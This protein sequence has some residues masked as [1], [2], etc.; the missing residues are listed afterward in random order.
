[1]LKYFL[2]YV[3]TGIAFCA[4]D[5]AWL[6]L[7]APKFY[8]AQIGQ[9]LL[10]KPNFLPALVFYVLYTGGLVVF[11]V[12]PAINADEWTHALVMGALFGLVAYAT[13]DLSNLATLKGWSTSL[14]LVDIAWGASASSA[15][16]IFGYFGTLFA[17]RFTS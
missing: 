12:S 3:A 11:C 7:V 4:L 1:M 9:L 15:A 14:T 8:Q 10:D 13:Y 17:N 6:T 5:F 16:S 2:A